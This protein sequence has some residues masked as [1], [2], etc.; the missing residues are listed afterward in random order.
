V[1]TALSSNAFGRVV[2]MAWVSATVCSSIVI[3][4]VALPG[5]TAR[6]ANSRKMETTAMTRLLQWSLP[7]T[8]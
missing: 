6:A 5:S 2:R 1:S 4:P 3:V 8:S 7:A